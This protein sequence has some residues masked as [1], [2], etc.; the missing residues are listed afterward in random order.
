MNKDLKNIYLIGM[1]GVG[2]STLGRLLANHLKWAFVDF[3][4]ILEAIYNRPINEINNTFSLLFKKLFD[5]GKAYLELVDSSDPLQAG[6]ELMVSPPGKK[7][8]KLSLLS[9]GEK[10]LTAIALVFSIF[11]LNP[12]PFCLLDEVD[13]PLDDANVGRY[14]ELVREMSRTIQFIYITH[15]KIA[16]EMGEQLMGVTMHEPGVSRLVSVNV[17]EAVAMAAV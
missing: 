15:N 2:K 17:D 11:A 1:E 8:Q 16:M 10:A 13:A 9:G 6:L 7:L 3:N 5:G 14:S 12:A 4:E